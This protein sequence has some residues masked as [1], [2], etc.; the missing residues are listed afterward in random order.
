MVTYIINTVP[1][2]ELKPLHTWHHLSWFLFGF[3]ICEVL[4][5]MIIFTAIPSSSKTI[6]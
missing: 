6:F 3:S 1:H 2:Q 5:L 4:D